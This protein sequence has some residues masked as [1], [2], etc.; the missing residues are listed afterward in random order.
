MSGLLRHGWLLLF[1]A[2]SAVYAYSA[3]NNVTNTL[4]CSTVLEDAAFPAHASALPLKIMILTDP[5][6]ITYLSGQSIRFR[7][8]LQHLVHFYPEDQVHLVTTDKIHPNPPSS[9]F[10]DKIP[11]HYTWGFRLPQYKSLTVSLDVSA[12][13][14]RLCGE[15]KFDLIHVSSPGM[16]LLPAVVASRLRGIP[17]LMSYHT[18]LPVYLRTYLPYPWNAIGEWITWRLLRWA[19]QFADLTVVTSPQMEHALDEH[20]IPSVLWPKGVNT[21]QFH[22][23]FK[24]QEMRHQMSQGNPDD[25]LVVYIGRLAREKRLTHLRSILEGLLANGIPTRLCIVGHGPEALDLQKYFQDTPTY[26]LGG[27]EGLA[28]SSAFASGDVF[29]MPSDSETLGF[30][31]ME[32]MA[33]GVPVV[34]SKAG[35][36]IDLVDDGGTGYLVPADD[37]DAFVEKIAWLY[38]NPTVRNQMAVQGR[39]AAEQW[40]WE[41][42]M[43]Y[44][45]QTSYLQAKGNVSQRFGK[46]LLRWFRSLI[47]QEEP[48]G[49][50]YAPKK[51]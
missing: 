24:S 45:R 39:H 37:T 30:V 38:Q 10:D 48:P 36:L 29:I 22:P 23:Q 49:S 19:H 8:L 7:T 40:S 47:R 28:L 16:Y 17:L 25:F 50:L 6:P 12:K 33:S 42:S 35:G 32:S 1:L 2:P 31:V 3:R 41:A 26:F 21:T 15:H 51:L 11:I 4:N 44:L 20:G 34:A 18:H 43:E 9:C 46:R 5:S 14:W 13:V 27:L